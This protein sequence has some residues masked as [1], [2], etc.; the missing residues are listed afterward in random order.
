VAPLFLDEKSISLR[1]DASAPTSI[2]ANS[3]IPRC[4]VSIKASE[5]DDGGGL[6]LNWGFS[7]QTKG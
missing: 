3:T 2:G 7:G 6:K 4:P 5:F 1:V